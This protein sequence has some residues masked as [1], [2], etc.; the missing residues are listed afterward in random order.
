MLPNPRFTGPVDVVDGRL[1][2]A[3][4]GGNCDYPVDLAAAL[5]PALYPRAAN[6]SQS[7]LVP[8]SGHNINAHYTAPKAYVQINAFLTA[9]GF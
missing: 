1:D 7:Y 6:G 4:C 5:I 8:E 3:A 2:F 9:N